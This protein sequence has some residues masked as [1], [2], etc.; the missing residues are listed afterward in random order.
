MLQNVHVTAY[1]PLGT[2]DSKDVVKREET[3]NL[4]HEPAVQAAA[5]KL[6]KSPVQIL[7]RWGLQHGTSVIPKATSEA[8]LKVRSPSLMLIK[9]EISYSS[10]LTP[11]EG[12]DAEGQYL[13]TR[14]LWTYFIYYELHHLAWFEYWCAYILQEQRMPIIQLF[15]RLCSVFKMECTLAQSNLSR[16]EK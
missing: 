15:G 8:H 11:A 2:P 3:P 6:G 9:A 14:G 5:E 12:Q 10:T 1:S 16:H 7:I 13:D 4:L